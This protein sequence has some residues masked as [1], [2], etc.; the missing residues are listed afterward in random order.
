MPR[1]DK[2]RA[3]RFKPLLSSSLN[4]SNNWKLTIDMMPSLQPSWMLLT[5][6]YLHCHIFN[7]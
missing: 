5:R 3:G 4:G 2:M 7:A 6:A 1:M